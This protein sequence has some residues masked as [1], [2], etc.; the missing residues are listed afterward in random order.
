VIKEKVVAESN[1]NSRL[2][3]FCDGVFAIALTLLIIEIKP[4][5]SETIKT[6]KDVWLALQ[7][8]LPSVFAFLL[9]FMVIFITWVNHHGTL[10][11]VNKSSSVFIYANG[12]L[13]LSIVVIPLPTS[14]L[15]EYLFTD[16][17]SPAVVLYSAVLALQSLSW[18]FLSQAALKPNPLTKNEKSTLTIRANQRNIYFALVVYT[19]CAIMAFWFPLV[20]ALLLGAIWLGWLVVSINIIGE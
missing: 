19:L 17:A 9:S 6:T 3:A 13:L 1:T 10:K 2:E 18:I 14:M 4:P 12:F 15:S 5:S 11:L 8:L 20:V 16:H 7:H